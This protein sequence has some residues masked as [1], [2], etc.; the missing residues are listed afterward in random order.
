MP[1]QLL[2]CEG[3]NGDADACTPVAM[4]LENLPYACLA[5]DDE[6]RLS[7]L[8]CKA[9]HLLENKHRTPHDLSGTKIWEAYPAW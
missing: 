3:S 5:L 4:S 8:N 2:S 6:W 9:V 1:F 7:C